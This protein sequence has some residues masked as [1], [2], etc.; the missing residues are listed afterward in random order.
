M[1]VRHSISTVKAGSRSGFGQALIRL[2][3]RV[4]EHH[5]LVA[6]TCL[7]RRCPRRFGLDAA[8]RKTSREPLFHPYC[9]TSNKPQDNSI[10]TGQPLAGSSSYLQQLSALFP[11][12][13]I[14]MVSAKSCNRLASWI[15]CPDG[16]IV[17]LV[18]V[19]KLLC[20]TRDKVSDRSFSALRRPTHDNLQG[21]A[22]HLGSARVGPR[23]LNAR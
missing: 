3:C 14:S 8:E 21:L 15:P 2:A 5:V 10:R 20:M 13:T 6:R 23:S 7:V 16:W 22:A 11:S 12:T 4:V 17:H 18:L 1:R 19:S 9:S